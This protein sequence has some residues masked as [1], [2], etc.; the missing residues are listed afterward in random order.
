[1]A[2]KDA[3]KAARNIHLSGHG[4]TFDG[5]IG[6]AAAVGLT[7]HGWSGRFIEYGKLRHI[8]NKVSVADLEKHNINVVS[9]DRDGQ[10]PAPGDFVNT[11]GWLRP[12]LWGKEAV[13]P[14]IPIEPGM[15]ESLGEKRRKNADISVVTA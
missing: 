11:K 2:Q 5:I 15:W 10:C 12:R 6:A 8:P 9:L 14:V 13:L 3:M 4:G 1:M 7:A